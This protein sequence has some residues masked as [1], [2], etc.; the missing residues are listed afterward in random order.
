MKAAKAAALEVLSAA[1]TSD[2][3]APLT[4]HE[5]TSTF[6]LPCN[7]CSSSIFDQFGVSSNIMSANIELRGAWFVWVVAVI[8]PCSEFCRKNDLNEE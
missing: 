7:T 2:T 5:V 6:A 1:T 8:V 4:R 3:R